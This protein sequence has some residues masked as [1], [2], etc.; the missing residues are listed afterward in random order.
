MGNTTSFSNVTQF[1]ETGGALLLDANAFANTSIYGQLSL[2][3]DTVWM[4]DAGDAPLG[5]YETTSSVAFE[6]LSGRWSGA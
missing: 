4:V 5:P 6:N 3:F 1:V 2:T